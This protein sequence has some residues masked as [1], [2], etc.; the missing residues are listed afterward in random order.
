MTHF[1]RISV[2]IPTRDRTNDLTDLIKTI[3]D[4]TRMPLQTIIVDGSKEG[5]ARQVTFSFRAKLE[6]CG[7]QLVYV[8]GGYDGLPTARNLGVQFAKGDA[9]FFLDDDILL[10]RDAI[11]ELS[12][13]LKNNETALGVEPLGIIDKKLLSSK[14]ASGKAWNTLAKILMLSYSE[15]NRY[16][17]RR[18][19]E[20]IF[21]SNITRP[22][23]AQR[24][25]GFAMCYRASVL[26]KYS[27]DTNLK[28][29]GYLEDLDFSYRVQSSNPN[30]LYAIPH[31]KVLHKVSS[32]SR[33]HADLQ[34]QMRTIYRFYIFFKTKSHE[35]ILNVPTFMLAQLGHLI[36]AVTR[37]TI[38][39]SGQDSWELIYFLRSYV[40]AFT[41]LRDILKADLEFFNNKV[42]AT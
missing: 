17:V 8:P 36:E 5:S 28:R 31:A 40:L 13:F 10:D 2:I 18:S 42:N 30:S 34:T 4:Q 37:L 3:L 16:C 23:L 19:G 33:M 7:C 27:F 39:R 41:N 9:I 20:S 12:S 29:W 32:E 1:P 38:T 22:M 14:L 15:K 6:S 26:K 24:L 25:R 35:S 21:P 11:H